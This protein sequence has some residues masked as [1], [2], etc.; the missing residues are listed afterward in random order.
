MSH[1]EMIKKK[2]VIVSKPLKDGMEEYEY[3][4]SPTKSPVQPRGGNDTPLRAA[5]SY[6]RSLKSSTP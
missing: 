2:A 6:E 5:D 1:K 3:A 4:M